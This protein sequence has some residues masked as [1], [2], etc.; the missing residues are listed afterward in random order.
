LALP[1][2]RLLAGNAAVAGFWNPT[3]GYLR[4]LAK[5]LKD[6]VPFKPAAKAIYDERAAG[7][8]WRE[9]PDANCLPQ[10]VPKVLLAPAPW[11]VVQTPE[12]IFFVHEAFNLWWKVFMNAREFVPSGDGVPPWL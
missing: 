1:L 8:R 7:L 3:M 2:R 5:D 10:G 4:D 12:R 6:A 9:E 11:R